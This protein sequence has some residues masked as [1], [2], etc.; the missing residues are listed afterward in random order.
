MVP[1]LVKAF[2]PLMQSSQ[3]MGIWKCLRVLILSGEVFD[4][5]LWQN[6]VKFLPRTSI[7]NLYG[8]TEVSY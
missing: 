3:P 8:S 1:S 5:S 7:L 4:L 2:L 6:L